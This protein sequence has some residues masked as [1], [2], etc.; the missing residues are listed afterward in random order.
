MNNI[1]GLEYGFDS[2]G[3]F[4]VIDHATRKAAYAY[5]TSPNAEAAKRNQR[6]IAL[7]MDPSHNATIISSLEEQHYLAVVKMT[8]QSQ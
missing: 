8:E 5:P 7:K 1:C 4:Y 2:K 3:G 6:A